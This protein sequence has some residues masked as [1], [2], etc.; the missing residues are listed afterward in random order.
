[1]HICVNKSGGFGRQALALQLGGRGQSERCRFVHHVGKI[2][3]TRSFIFWIGRLLSNQKD[4][5]CTSR[6]NFPTWLLNFTIHIMCVRV[7]FVYMYNIC[8]SSNT[9]TVSSPIT[10]IM[11]QQLFTSESELN[12]GASGAGAPNPP[13]PP[14]GF[15]RK[16]VILCISSSSSSQLDSGSE[17]EIETEQKK[18]EECNRTSWKQYQQ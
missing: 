8:S 7:H 15:Y 17:T 13:G 9:R 12:G 6:R 3:C 16:P 1:M 18:N 10:G 5:N 11:S 4:V 2:R 14:G